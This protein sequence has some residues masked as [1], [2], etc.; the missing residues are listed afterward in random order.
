MARYRTAKGVGGTPHLTASYPPE[1]TAQIRATR[2]GQAHWAG[3]GPAGETCGKCAFHGYWQQVCNAAG[4]NIDTRHRAG[5]AKFLRS[6]AGMVRLSP[7]ALVHVGIS[8]DGMSGRDPSR[9]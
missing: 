9:R 6:P 5:C 2:A 1:L 4:D 7:P 8:S 3:A